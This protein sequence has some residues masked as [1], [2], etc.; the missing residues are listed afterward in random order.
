MASSIFCVLTVGLIFVL[1]KADI[2]LYEN[3][4]ENVVVAIGKDVPEHP[5][6]IENIKVSPNHLIRKKTI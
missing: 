2:V 5:I 3:G 1:T 6:I 4:Y